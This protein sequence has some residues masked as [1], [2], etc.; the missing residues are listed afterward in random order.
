MGIGR[1]H[2]KAYAEHPG[3]QLVAVVDLDP[4]RLEPW[5]ATVGDEGLF[6]DYAAML[7]ALKPDLV[8]VALPNALHGRV[9]ID[10]L[11]AGAHVLCEK[12]MATSMKEAR[13]MQE[14]ARKAGRRLGINLSYR[15]TAPARAL[16]DLADDG[17]LGTPYHA[18]TK[19]TRRDG[20]P[21]F[22]GWFGRKALSGGGPL[23]DLGVHRLDLAMWL[24]GSPE[25]VTVSGAIHD[26][27]A[28][29]RA[30]ASGKTFDVED[31]ST[32]FV[33]FANG[34]SLV[35]ETSWAGHQEEPESMMTMVM[36]TQGSLVHRNE[37]GGYQFVGEC[38]TERAGHRLHSRIHPDSRATSNP[39][40]EMV[41]AIRE[42]RPY[43]ADAEDGLRVQKILDGLYKSAR[44]GREVRL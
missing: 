8:S 12:P 14:E 43:L 38:F 3:S 27:I 4:A 20:F 7:R 22:G 17:F 9:T 37:G 25:P 34:A 23:I 19:W 5:R 10:A 26:H 30:A 31:F 13:K 32:G 40:Q 33:R 11:R 28:K 29:A 16:K 1:H 44:T 15:F 2:A 36:G 21:G 42:D 18:V 6:D 41:A 39:Y 24:M 35:F